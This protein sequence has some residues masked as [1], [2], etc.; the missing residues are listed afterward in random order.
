MDP[1]YG[2]SGLRYNITFRKFK[3][4]HPAQKDYCAHL[5]AFISSYLSFL[6]GEKVVHG[7]QSHFARHSCTLRAKQYWRLYACVKQ[8]KVTLKPHILGC[9]KS[10][11]VTSLL[12]VA[13]QVIGRHVNKWQP[14]QPRNLVCPSKCLRKSFHLSIADSHASNAERIR[15]LTLVYDVPIF[16]HFWRDGL[17]R[18]AI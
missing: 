10:R 17:V 6:E 8:F 7:K 11:G 4:W 13:R 3:K 2:N 15:N 14:S 12:N 18:Y 5:R 16:A 9:P 1:N